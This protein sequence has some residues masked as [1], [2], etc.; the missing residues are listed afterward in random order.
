MQ[1][2][3]GL[4]LEWL[5]HQLSLIVHMVTSS[6]ICTFWSC[7]TREPVTSSTDPNKLK[8][9]CQPSHLQGSHQNKSY[10]PTTSTVKTDI[11][12]LR[13]FYCSALSHSLVPPHHLYPQYFTSAPNSNYPKDCDYNVPWNAGTASTYEMAEHWA[14]VTHY[15]H[16]TV[17]ITL[18]Q[19]L[20]QHCDT[21]LLSTSLKPTASVTVNGIYEE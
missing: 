12:W 11:N 6:G 15:I 7:E 21:E 13:L 18:N 8:T 4:L 3:P 19:S 10:I 14:E 5:H 20:F 1:Q 2:L 9:P 17:R 16:T